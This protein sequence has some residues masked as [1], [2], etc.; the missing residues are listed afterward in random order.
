[1]GGIENAGIGYYRKYGQQYHA[2]V[3]HSITILD[4]ALKSEA[5][6]QKHDKGR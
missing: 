1:M 2:Q 4:I 3:I 6:K 5:G